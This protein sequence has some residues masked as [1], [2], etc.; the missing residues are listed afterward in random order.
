MRRIGTAS[1]VFAIVLWSVLLGVNSPEANQLDGRQIFRF[2]TFGDEQ[3]W[4][5]PCACTRLSR[6]SIRRPRSASD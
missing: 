1:T 6:H 2:D 4:T 3:L 5:D